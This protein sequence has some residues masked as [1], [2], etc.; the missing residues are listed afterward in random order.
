M[1]RIEHSP[2]RVV[3]A[4][5]RAWLMETGLLLQATDLTDA[6]RSGTV[7]NSLLD[8]LR[9]E[10]ALASAEEDS[11]FP[12]LLEK[13]PYLVC[14]FEQEHRHIAQLRREVAEAEHALRHFPSNDQVAG[15]R[16]AY[17]SYMA[18]ILQHGMR[19]ESI[20]MG[21][22]MADM[23]EGGS[24]VAVEA[25]LERLGAEICGGLMGRILS[26]MDRDQRSQVWNGL[27]AKGPDFRKA[28]MVP[29]T[30]PTDAPVRRGR[31]TVAA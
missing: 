26:G 18:F 4:G 1:T 5:M 24:P 11:L 23:K 14:H 15:L 20:L 31:L 12:L 7:R 30:G 28:L 3:Y 9:V 8:L 16:L 2:I 13:A 22:G 21:S 17:T 19:E 6:G 27:V 10:A 29:E 25:L